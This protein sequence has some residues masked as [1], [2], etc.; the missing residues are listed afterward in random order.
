MASIDNKI[1]LVKKKWFIMVYMKKF[2][3]LSFIYSMSDIFFVI[4]LSVITNRLFGRKHLC[5]YIF[6][7]FFS[8][9]SISLF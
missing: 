9:P 2:V 6:F 5:I 1:Y 3:F 4:L 7:L 8:F